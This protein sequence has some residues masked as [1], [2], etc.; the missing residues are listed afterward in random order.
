MAKSLY[1]SPPPKLSDA[2]QSAKSPDRLP[3][4]PKNYKLLGLGIAVL[5]L[6]F[7]LLSLEKFKD[8]QEGFSIALHVAPVVILAGYAEIIYAIMVRDNSP[9]A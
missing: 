4:G 1:P 2:V 7:F 3:F 8:A 5:A 6:G 9:R